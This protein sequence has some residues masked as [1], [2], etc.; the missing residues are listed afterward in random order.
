VLKI[1]ERLCSL[2]VART[3]GSARMVKLL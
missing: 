1:P 3:S 2:D